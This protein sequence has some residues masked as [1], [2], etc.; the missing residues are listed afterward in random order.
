MR[1]PHRVI[2]KLRLVSLLAFTTLCLLIFGYLWVNSGGRLAGVSKSGYL[3]S[4]DIP[5]VNNL[6]YDSDVRMA[7]IQI[8]KVSKLEVDGNQARVTM[9]LD[10]NAPLHT[11]A[12]VQ[13][14]AKTLVEETFLDVTDGSG[15]ALADHATL[16][17]GS[18]KEGTT[19]NDLLVSLDK[20]TLTALSGVVN[21]LGAESAD[22]RKSI[23]QA[24]SGL[25]EVGREGKDVLAA[26]SAQS[27]D[28]QQ[29]TTNAA[30][31][32]SALNTRQGEIAQVVSQANQLTKATANQ[33]DDLAATMRTLPALMDTARAA[34]TSL[35]SL[36]T[37][38]AP[39]AA[40][41]KA[42]APDVSAALLQLP[43]TTA[44][45]R[46]LLPSLNSVLDSAPATLDLI[47]ATSRLVRNLIPEL[48]VD[49]ADV[50][51]MLSYVQP[52][53]RDLAAF[54]VNFVPVV[55]TG[56]ANGRMMRAF[57]IANEQTLRNFPISTNVGPLDKF[58][59]FP[60][61]KLDKPGPW[62]GKYPRIEAEPI[63]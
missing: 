37:N 23:S 5:R 39:V 17:A 31:L 29:L 9:R 41:L 36:G 46:A 52:Y 34:G 16:P 58:N 40:D 56:D 12:I 2:P 55:A 43:R 62:S 45:L 6:V 51:P 59:P 3:V 54:F 61:G 8:G 7:G 14:R 11:G 1:I 25:G 21:S 63:K 60:Q 4:V 24:L 32:L 33:S 38:L 10:K 20:P 47:P 27:G 19:V 28:L 44:D 18:G 50:N 53:G 35:A 26:L 57:L 30:A 49:L 48:K 42:A 22:S 13:V 15:P